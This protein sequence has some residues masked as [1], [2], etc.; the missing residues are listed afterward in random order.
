MK[1]LQN[2]VL[3]GNKLNCFNT[4]QVLG[5]PAQI[6]I[7]G[8]QIAKS[9]TRK[10]KGGPGALISRRDLNLGGGDLKFYGGTYETQSK[11]TW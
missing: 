5:D 10:I 3:G 1:L 9:P 8:S 4:T 6:L 11:V 7:R 2:N